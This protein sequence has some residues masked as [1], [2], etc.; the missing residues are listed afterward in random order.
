[1]IPSSEQ[2]AENIKKHVD[3]MAK[4]VARRVGCDRWPE[5]GC[6]T[7]SGPHTCEGRAKVERHARE[8]MLDWLLGNWVPPPGKP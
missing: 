4:E 7:L 3:A 6:G 1:M 5:C 2:V 8:V